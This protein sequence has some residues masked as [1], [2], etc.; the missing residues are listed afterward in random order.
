MPVLDL[1]SASSPLL[2]T[3]RVLPRIVINEFLRAFGPGF[4]YLPAKKRVPRCAKR[5]VFGLS[6]SSSSFEKSLPTV[7]RCRRV[8]KRVKFRNDSC[9]S[10]IIYIYME[11]QTGNPYR[12]NRA[13]GRTRVV[14]RVVL[15]EGYPLIIPCN[16]AFDAHTGISPLSI[17]L[18]TRV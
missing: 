1:P 2:Q 9:N 15:L 12:L 18:K 11:K 6:S 4:S 14:T 7:A 17:P 16:D 13:G 10:N 8:S 5:I 3:C